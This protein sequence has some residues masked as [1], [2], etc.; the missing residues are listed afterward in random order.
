MKVLIVEDEKKIADFMV[1]GLKSRGFVV[2]CVADGN[3]A[4]AL[5]ETHPFD[6]LVL[7]I[8]LPG[9]DGLSV[10]KALRQRGVNVPVILLTARGE[11]EDRIAGFA[12]G[13]DDYLVKP[14]FVD[15]L[16]ARLHAIQRRISSAQLNLRQVGALS[17]NL[18]T[19]EVRMGNQVVELT[20]REFTLVEFLMRSPGRVF[21]RTQILEY[22]WNYDFDPNTN[23]VDVC[24]RRIRR[25]LEPYRADHLIETIR[26][27]GYRFRK[28]AE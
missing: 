3:D 17:L 20:P 27:V 24:I 9:R 4:L 21:T 15:E 19:R 26:G 2:D 7:D 13:A 25:K 8:M 28:E 10:L 18:A 6:A 12:H 11:L 14:F 23:V 5:A 22:V 1:R 16:I